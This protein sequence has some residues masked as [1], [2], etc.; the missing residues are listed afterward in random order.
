MHIDG[1][2]DMTT[3]EE[4]WNLESPFT[5][6]NVGIYIDT[7]D[8]EKIN[9]VIELSNENKKSVYSDI[10]FSLRTTKQGTSFGLDITAVEEH[11]MKI[12]VIVTVHLK[13]K[14]VRPLFVF[15]KGVK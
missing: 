7:L 10:E 6:E 3:W 14:N 9:K 12:D 4:S 1:A 2:A 5:I 11:S 8:G 13:K 15:E